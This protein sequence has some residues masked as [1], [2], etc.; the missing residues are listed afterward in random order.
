MPIVL[1]IAV[2]AFYFPSLTDAATLYF[3]NSSTAVSTCGTTSATYNDVTKSCGSGTLR[4][5]TS[6]ATG[7]TASASGDTMIVRGGTIYAE[8]FNDC[9]KSGVGPGFTSAT[10]LIAY[11]G[12]TP[13]FRPN[14]LVGGA[15]NVYI[16][17]K[18]SIIIDGIEW[19]GSRCT[20]GGAAFYIRNLTGLPSYIRIIRNHIHDTYSADGILIACDF[21]EI[22]NNLI[23]DIG[24]FQDPAPPNPHAIYFKVGQ[25]PKVQG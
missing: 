11:P 13:V 21:C 4:V 10:T 19:D 23:H 6:A 14:S 9:L 7:C 24:L 1:I 16:E 5:Y 2:F 15:C 20:S 18:H 17:N 25:N 22:Q 12:E 8:N 3:D